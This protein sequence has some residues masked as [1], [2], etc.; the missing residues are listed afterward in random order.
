MMNNQSVAVTKRVLAH[1]RSIRPASPS[2]GRRRLVFDSLEDRTM[3][4]ITIAALG[5]SL[6]DE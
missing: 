5:D 3:L 1:S 6:T 4:S 2:T